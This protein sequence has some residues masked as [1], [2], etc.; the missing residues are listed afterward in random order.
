MQ[1]QQHY[2]IVVF[3]HSLHGRL[4]RVHI[5]HH[6]IYGVLALALAGCVSVFG[7]VSS[8]LRMAWKTANY[9]SLL[10]EIST[11]RAS[12]KNLEKSN[13]QTSDQLAQL[14]IFASEVSMAYGLKAKLE[15]PS[16]ISSEG[17]LVPTISESL[18]EYDLL[19]TANFS[20][21]S[22]RYQRPWQLN[23]RPSIWPVDGQLGSY[24]GERSDPFSGEGAFHTGVD[25]RA[26][27][28]TPVHAAADGVVLRASFVGGYG[29][30]V[31]IDHGNG[32]QTYY[33][34]LS[35]FAVVPGQEV[36]QGEV[37]GLV[38]SS[39]R[40]TAPHLHYEVREHGNPENPRY[41]LN[42]PA[43]QPVRKYFPF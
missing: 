6:V 31:V 9:N 7:F 11:L 35:R 12:Y 19:R 16:D 30:L 13:H 37:V 40:A 20:A 1:Q 22:H 4:R 5:P 28:G 3:A 14:Q 34:H 42:R 10:K 43:T 27:S 41:F 24:F 33:A 21:S 8:Y 15:G 18:A 25:I 39:G 32:L 26:P 2:F 38:G 36:R 29:R 17:K 23:T